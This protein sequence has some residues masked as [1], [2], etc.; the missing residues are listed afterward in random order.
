MFLGDFSQFL[1]TTEFSFKSYYLTIYKKFYKINNIK[2][3]LLSVQKSL[4]LNKYSIMSFKI[5]SKFNIFTVYIFFNI[6]IKKLY[7]DIEAD[8]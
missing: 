3:E 2:I 1:N 7:I 6:I 5:T 8:N 4:I